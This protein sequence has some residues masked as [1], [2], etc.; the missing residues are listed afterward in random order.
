M[1]WIPNAAV[2]ITMA[3]LALVVWRLYLSNKKALASLESASIGQKLSDLK[4][5]QKAM[6]IEMK[7]LNGTVR[8]H[9]QTLA[10]L[11]EAVSHKQDKGP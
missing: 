5:E 4:L 8:N 6:R 7:E 2:L 9:S 11:V 10:T 3:G 1:T